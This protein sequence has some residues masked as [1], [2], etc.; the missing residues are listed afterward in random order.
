[1]EVGRLIGTRVDRLVRARIER[2]LS[3]RGLARAAGLSG[4]FVSQIETGRRNPGPAAARKICEALGARFDDLF[5]ICKRGGGDG[6][7]G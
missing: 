2:G 4:P 1:M 7:A 6:A 5:Y 3:Q